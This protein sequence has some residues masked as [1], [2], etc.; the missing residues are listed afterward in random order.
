MARGGPSKSQLGRGPRKP[1]EAEEGRRRKSSSVSEE[2]PAGGGEQRR[3]VDKSRTH[4]F[5]LD[6]EQGSEGLLRQRPG[7][8][9]DRNPKHPRER[10]ERERS[11]SDERAKHKPKSEKRG[12]GGE[13]HA[14]E[15]L[16]KDPGY[17]TKGTVDDKAER[18]SKSRGDRRSSTSA[19][20]GRSSVS[21]GGVGEEGGAKRARI[22]SLDAVRADKGK[23]EKGASKGEVR[24]LLVPQE[25]TGSS[26][27]RSDMEPGSEVAKRKDRQ[28][29]DAPK[30]SKSQSEFRDAAVPDRRARAGSDSDVDPG[31]KVK[32]AA[33]KS[34]S[35]SR[36]DPKAQA[37]PRG[38]RKSSAS[39]SK[40][41]GAK[42]SK[43]RR[44]ESTSKEEKR[45][46]GSLKEERKVSEEAA[47]EKARKGA[48]RKGA[49][50]EKKPGEVQG[51]ETGRGSKADE[52]SPGSSLSPPV[53]DTST[54]APLPDT[55]EA[56]LAAPPT[57]PPTTA[58][59]LSDDAFD[60][61][62]DITPE[63]EDE[64]EMQIDEEADAAES[65]SRGPSSDGGFVLG[66]GDVAAGWPRQE[67][68]GMGSTPSEMSLRE[69]ALTLLSMDPDTTTSPG[70][71]AEDV[72]PEPLPTES[73][74][75]EAGGSDGQPALPQA[76]L[77]SA[78]AGEALGYVET[79]TP[80]Q[81]AV[82][83]GIV[84]Q[85]RDTQRVQN[86]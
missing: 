64:G 33:E 65:P 81:Q 86:S 52:P 9:F 29:K 42:P 13:A 54:P 73:R 60:A 59:G 3:P 31:S 8:K 49:E 21:E 83:A 17:V 28:P 5:I 24:L 41:K 16:L 76:V 34:R 80:D 27:D 37:T 23:G 72:S 25:S 26:E 30:R 66:G 58:A 44:R 77:V 45:R 47:A 35:R 20:D 48:E 51:E 53:P 82:N 7:G 71:A 32:T 74:D 14:E 55:T 57:A 10:G 78:E 63:P 70:V 69:A 18:K 62:S 79:E 67:R 15:S 75:H 38:E 85:T 11:L 4:S 12:A 56:L 68:F 50:A 22:V 39:E 84:D 6:L 40:G 61:L 46:E 2:G 1:A 36:E 43:E 19:R